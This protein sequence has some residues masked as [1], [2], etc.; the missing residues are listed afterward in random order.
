MTTIDNESL[1]AEPAPEQPQPRITEVRCGYCT[2]GRVKRY[3]RG[4]DGRTIEMLGYC[5]VCRGRG[6]IT[7]EA[8]S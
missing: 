6:V 5:C 7:V 3:R 1:Q 2:N 8:E 4:N